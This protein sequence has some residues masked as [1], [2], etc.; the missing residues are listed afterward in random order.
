MREGRKTNF[1]AHASPRQNRLGGIA[2]R[3]D[4]LSDIEKRDDAAWTA[5][6]TFVAPRKRADE[7][8]L[9][10]HEL[11]VAAEILGMQEPFLERPVIDSSSFTD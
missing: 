9:V 10:E 6:E 2:D 1:A 4:V 11:D 3:L 5:L 7:R 8:A